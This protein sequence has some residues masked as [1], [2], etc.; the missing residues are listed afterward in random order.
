MTVRRQALKTT[1]GD[2]FIELAR[3]VDSDGFTR[4]VPVTEFKDKYL[5][6]RFGNGADWARSDGALGKK[7]NIARFKE[8]AGNAITHVQLQGFNKSPNIDRRIKN[9]IRVKIQSKRCSVLA[10]SK[11][12]EV[13]HKD[14]RYDDNL[15]SNLST[16]SIDQFQPLSKAVNYAKRQHC[17]ICKSTGQRFDARQLGYPVSQVKG[18]GK[19]RGTCIGCYWYDPKSFNKAMKFES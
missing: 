2:L 10:I 17:K 19:Y 13:D 8:G 3:G 1:K 4:K 12:I 7:F 5:I 9:K 14:G 15:V 11:D 6:L 18:N 16:Q